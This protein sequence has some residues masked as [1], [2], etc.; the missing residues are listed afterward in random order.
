MQVLTL[1]FIFSR[2]HYDYEE[3]MS[4]AEI[5]SPVT[6]S[7]WL[8]LTRES[9]FSWLQD[10][11]ANE[12]PLGGPGYTV[13]IDETK[14]GHRKYNTGRLI[15]GQWILGIIL[16]CDT[17]PRKGETISDCMPLNSYLQEQVFAWKF[18]KTTKGM[19]PP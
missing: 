14:V 10:Q 8:S 5:N 18:A 3:V 19:R 9:C 15:E 16:R 6:V 13:E 2:G 11:Y 4:E 7:D 17:G 12:G 1:L